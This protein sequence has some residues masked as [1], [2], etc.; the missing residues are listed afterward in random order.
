MIS[1][2]LLLV[3]GIVVSNYSINCS[4]AD[5]C[6]LIMNLEICIVALYSHLCYNVKM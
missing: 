3:S 2:V 4:I 1:S 6:C 5:T